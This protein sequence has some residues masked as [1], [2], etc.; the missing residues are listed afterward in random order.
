MD[1]CEKHLP[2]GSFPWLSRFIQL[3]CLFLCMSLSF[4]STSE[5]NL[6]IKKDNLGSKESASQS[7]ESGICVSLP[8]ILQIYLMWAWLFL[9][10]CKML[11]KEEKELC[12]HSLE[13]PLFPLVFQDSPNFKWVLLP[14]LRSYLSDFMSWCTWFWKYGQCSKNT[15]EW[16]RTCEACCAV[17]QGLW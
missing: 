9:I 11:D 13:Q 1:V 15:Q 6:L 8:K 12:R 7:T 14:L 10:F 2:A 4:L 3:V 16:R 5:I 17:V